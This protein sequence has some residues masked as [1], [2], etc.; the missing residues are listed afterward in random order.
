MALGCFPWR[1]NE[2]LTWEVCLEP[3]ILSPASG[4]PHP[5]KRRGSQACLSSHPHVA[6]TATCSCCS[7][8]SRGADTHRCSQ[9]NLPASLPQCRYRVA[10]PGGNAC[11]SAAVPAAPSMWLLPSCPLVPP[12]GSGGVFRAS[13]SRGPRGSAYSFPF[14][15]FVCCLSRPRFFPDVPRFLF[16][17]L[18]HESASGPTIVRTRVGSHIHLLLSF[19]TVFFLNK[20]VLL[21]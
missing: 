5:S 12:A 4:R 19:L 17:H 16:P 11:V 6:D 7:C 15:C 20:G 13:P 3:S 21:F 9:S 8:L 14:P 2:G 10:G 1:K 18:V